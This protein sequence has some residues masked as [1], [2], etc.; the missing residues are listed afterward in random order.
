MKWSL[1]ALLFIFG[2][3]AHADIIHKLSHSTQLTVDAAASVSTRMGSSYSASGSNIKVATGG[4]FGGLTAGSATAAATM[5]DGTYE[6][7]T[8]GQAYSF[9]ESYTQGDAINTINSGSTVTSGVV[10]SLPAY[11]SVTTYSG[12]VAGNLAGSITSAAGGTVSLTSGGAGTTAIGQY[13]SEL[14]VLQ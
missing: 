4:S 7:N 12:G 13:T 5:T 9:S 6:I 1:A 14:S 8:A 11:G 3:P 2:A 10:P